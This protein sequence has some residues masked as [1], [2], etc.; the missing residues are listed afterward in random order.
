MGIEDI[1]RCLPC[2]TR[3]PGGRSF[4]TAVSRKAKVVCDAKHSGDRPVPQSFSDGGGMVALPRAGFGPY[5]TGEAAR[6]S[7]VTPPSYALKLFTKSCANFL[8]AAS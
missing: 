2:T 3:A 7:G 4:L 8:A 6:T 5:A 1:F